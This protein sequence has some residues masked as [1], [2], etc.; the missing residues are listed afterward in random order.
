MARESQQRSFP[1]CEA[2]PPYSQRSV[3]VIAYL[4]SHSLPVRF[5]SSLA[6]HTETETQT[7][8]QLPATLSLSISCSLLSLSSISLLSLLFL[9][10]LSHLL[11]GSET[12]QHSN[13]RQD[14]T[15][16]GRQQESSVGV[17]SVKRC[18]LHV[19]ALLVG[20]PVAS[21]S[22]S[23]NSTCSGNSLWTRSRF[24]ACPRYCCCRPPTTET[25]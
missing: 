1:A 10:Y 11:R 16:L 13:A 24:A 8:T 3:V 21:A 6:R 18:W 20:D 19:P 9:S 25:Q 2:R 15:A 17:G 22:I 23:G 4:H 12:H 14:K 7:P 5:V